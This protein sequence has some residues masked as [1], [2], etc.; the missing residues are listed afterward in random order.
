MLF[1]PQAAGAYLLGCAPAAPLT[2]RVAGASP[3]TGALE[4]LADALKGYLAV[5]LLS[6]GISL[7]P[8][9]V[10]TAV[11]AGHQWPAFWS[12]PGRSAGTAVLVG[13]LTAITPLAAPLWAAL[14]GLAFV[15]TGYVQASSLAATALILPAIGLSAG[16]PLALFSLPPT[17]MVLSR[18]GPMWA[19]WRRGEEPKYLWRSGS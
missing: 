8:A 9:L 18:L 7:G 14:W 6:P 11:V 13:A 4:V 19:S 17:G 15:I 10:A 2:R 16:W 12:E 1:L 5:T 3:W